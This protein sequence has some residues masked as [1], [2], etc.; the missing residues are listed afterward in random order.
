MFPTHNHA[1]LK[2]VNGSYVQPK[3]TCALQIG[4]SGRILPFEFIVL[5]DCS[6]DIILGWNFLKAS[7]ALIDCRR[8]ELT[9]DDVEVTS[10]EIVFKPLHLC[11]MK[12]CSGRGSRVV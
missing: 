3:G 7:G 2:V 9:L 4:I 8:S 11:V 6:N 10:E 1:V 12:D 5:P